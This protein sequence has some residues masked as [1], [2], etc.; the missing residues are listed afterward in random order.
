MT[1]FTS[2]ASIIASASSV[3]LA[4][5]MQREWWKVLML[6][7]LAVM[8]AFKHRE[9]LGRM[10]AGIEPACSGLNDA[11]RLSALLSSAELLSNT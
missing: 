6:G 11:R 3:I 8:I 7:G 1:R 9:N 2:A 5:A 4:V 10:Y